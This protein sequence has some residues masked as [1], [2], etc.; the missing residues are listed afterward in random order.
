[1]RLT[2]DAAFADEFQAERE[3]AAATGEE[4]F[5]AQVREILKANPLFEGSSNGIIDRCLNPAEIRRYSPGEIIFAELSE[6]NEIFMIVEGE[7][8]VAVA[9]LNDD[10][11]LEI[12]TYSV[13]DVF[14][15]GCFFK[16][17]LPRYATVTAKSNTTVLVWHSDNWREIAESDF[18]LG[19]RLAVRITRN[20][21]ERLRRWN[22]KVVENTSWGLD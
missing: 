8:S 12:I 19:Y 13:G 2:T 14:G 6:G 20:F 4:Q 16:P 9:L 22:L 5:M 17:N 1:M 15:E 18:E 11:S 3:V 7:A 10:Q 21:L